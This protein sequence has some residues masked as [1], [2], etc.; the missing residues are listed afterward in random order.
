M[1]VVTDMGTESSFSPS[2]LSLSLLF[3]PSMPHMLATHTQAG[4]LSRQE[5]EREI[6]HMRR[7]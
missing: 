5:R 6:T 1:L 7:H 4:W 3:V 2:F